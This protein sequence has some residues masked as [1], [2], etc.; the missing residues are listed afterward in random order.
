ME[1][2]FFFEKLMKIPRAEFPR[3]PEGKPLGRLE[4]AAKITVTGDP[5]AVK[6][7]SPVARPR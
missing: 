4:D 1:Q 6:R 3:R 2:A 5:A 7:L